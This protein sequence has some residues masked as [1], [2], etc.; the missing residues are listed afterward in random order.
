[1]NTSDNNDLMQEIVDVKVWANLGL[2]F[3][4]KLK[5]AVALET[6]RVKGGEDNK[7]MAVKH[8]EKALQFWNIVIDITRLIYSDMPL[9]HYSSQ[10][11]KNWKEN[12]HLRFH[13]EKL[14]PEVAKDIEF[15]KSATVYSAE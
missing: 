6:Y 4:E 13:W 10:D 8:L 5:G 3:A 9:V 11:G 7:R 1:M 12:N 14:R 2:Y 15:A